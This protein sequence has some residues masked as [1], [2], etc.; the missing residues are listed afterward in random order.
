M[1]TKGERERVVQ[2][3]AAHAN[4]PK[5]K[6][7]DSAGKRAAARGRRKDR[8][9]NPESHNEAERAERSS[10]YLF[11]VSATGRPSRKSSRR[12]GTRVKPDAPLRITAMNRVSSPKRRAAQRGGKRGGK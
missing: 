9:P 1:S 10:P 11:E 2:Q 12:S 8:F 7:H 6:G 4:H 3:R 5:R